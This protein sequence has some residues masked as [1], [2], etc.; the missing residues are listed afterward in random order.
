MR[1]TGEKNYGV[2]LLRR[3][4]VLR[5]SMGLL[6]ALPEH[7]TARAA[8]RLSI[9]KILSPHELVYREKISGIPRVEDGEFAH[10]LDRNRAAGTSGVGR[11]TRRMNPH[12]SNVHESGVTPQPGASEA[13]KHYVRPILPDTSFAECSIEAT[14]SVSVPP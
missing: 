5:L 13:V 6:N 3:D 12:Y 2:A 14:N 7:T 11:V 10:V 9:R 4:V 1:K 8:A